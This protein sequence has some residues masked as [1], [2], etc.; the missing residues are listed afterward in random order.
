MAFLS[1]LSTRTR[2]Y[3]PSLKRAAETVAFSAAGDAPDDRQFGLLLDPQHVGPGMSLIEEVVPPG[4]GTPLHM[5]VTEGEWFYFVR[6]K[7]KA[8]VGAD[9]LDLDA[10]HSAFIPAGTPHGWCNVGDETGTVLFGFTPS[11]K[12]HLL[13]DKM[14]KLHEYDAD[15]LKDVYDVVVFPDSRGPLTPDSPFFVTGFVPK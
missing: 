4:A 11:D 3:A 13:T 6:G 8:V 10:G 15:T 1:R 2:T 7:F 9:V 14:M 5:H 12:G